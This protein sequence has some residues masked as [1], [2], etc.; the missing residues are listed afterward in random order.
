[1]S[2]T[3]DSLMLGNP[4]E[5][6]ENEKIAIRIFD[7]CLHQKESELLIAP[8]SN[9]VYIKTDKIYII[10]QNQEIRIING[11]Y[12]YDLHL[13][14]AP[15]EKMRKKFRAEIEKRVKNMEEKIVAK[16]KGSLQNILSEISTTQ[17]NHN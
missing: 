12:S 1:M 9:T 16:T 11:R 14:V 17:E 3:I 2:R 8:L 15:C 10:L 13:P 7:K 6:E 5:P 4:A